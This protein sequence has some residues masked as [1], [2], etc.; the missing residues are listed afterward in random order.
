VCRA[1][2]LVYRALLHSSLRENHQRVGGQAAQS[3]LG[4]ISCK[5]IGLFCRDTGFFWRKSLRSARAGSTFKFGWN[6]LLKYT[7]LCCLPSHFLVISA[8]R[9]LYLCKRVL[10]FCKRFHPNMTVFGWNVLLK[11]RALLQRYRILLA[12]ITKKCE[13]RQHSQVRVECVAEI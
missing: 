11:Y 2:L 9:A 6:V 3:Y 5:N 12:E 4:G 7:A 13:G 8:K 10:Y 1:L